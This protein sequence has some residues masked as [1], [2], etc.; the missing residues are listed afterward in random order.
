MRTVSGMD[1]AEGKEKERKFIRVIC[2]LVKAEFIP[3][4]IACFYQD[5]VNLKYSSMEFKFLTFLKIINGHFIRRKNLYIIFD[6]LVSERERR[7]PR[8]VT[9][10]TNV[11]RSL[12]NWASFSSQI[13]EV[14]RVSKILSST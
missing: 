1:L 8:I 11:E 13:K 12:I 7:N 9:L 6:L 5:I 3:Y 2:S 4:I 10:V 14:R